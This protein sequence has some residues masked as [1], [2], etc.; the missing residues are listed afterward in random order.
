MILMMISMQ[1]VTSFVHPSTSTYRNLLPHSTTP[2]FI[3]YEASKS[4]FTPS[5]CSSS[6][7]TLF[8]KLWDG[9]ETVESDQVEW[10]LL[11][12]VA[13]LEKD[14]LAQCR[15]MCKDYPKTDIVRFAVPTIREAR[16]H[17]KR[18]VVEDI[19][20][21]PGYVFAQLR[22]CEEVYEEISSLITCRSWMGT[23]R[24]QGHRRL[25]SVPLPLSPEEI[26]SFKGLEDDM[27]KDV[28]KTA[29]ELLK[30]YEGFEVEG[31]VKI[32]EGKHAGEDGIVKRLKGG[33]ISVRLFTYGSQF[34]EW[35]R[36]DQ[37]RPLTELE[38]MRGLT[39]RESPIRQDDFDQS[40]GKPA[41]PKTRGGMEQY[42][43]ENSP[44]FSK[45]NMR[46]ELMGNVKGMRQP[47]NRQQDRV[48]RGDVGGRE[49]R[50]RWGNS[51]DQLQEEKEAWQKYQKGETDQ[52]MKRNANA[53]DV[54]SQWG[55][56]G[57]T[58]KQRKKDRNDVNL[59]DWSQ[60]T[61]TTSSD[62][63]SNDKK[64]DNGED[65]FFNDLM[66]ELS[67]TLED[68]PRPSQSNT[69]PS[70]NSEDD[71]FSSLMS[72]LSEND[73]DGSSAS[74]PPKKDPVDTSSSDPEED[75]FA[76]L[77]KEISMLSDQDP[78][79]STASTDMESILTSDTDGGGM[80]S[81]DDFFAQL[82]SSLSSDLDMEVLAEEAPPK[83]IESKSESKSESESKS[84][85]GEVSATS[86]GT[87]L[88]KLT[89]PVLKSML[90]E[91]GLKVSGKKAELIDRLMN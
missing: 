66:S 1:T 25:P 78:S 52:E 21:Y 36:P 28:E 40:M 87:D 76:S 9:I 43:D 80:D 14:L 53:Y 6:S 19:V 44:R 68:S 83:A 35:L 5:S 27:E 32:L 37:I 65:D 54:D 8:G 12:C 77:E 51:R 75:F 15:E 56:S 26:T 89:V 41:R 7:T 79:P 70:S 22:L 45:R 90:K 74:T 42:S 20:L 18:N 91:K 38:L 82:E 31:M 39:G 2:S 60:F 61:S 59:D 64:S 58:P 48:G 34:D 49:G 67:T 4:K 72:E 33:K 55:R 69:E 3:Q 73:D 24:R 46:N 10:Y 29:E 23:Q 88:S 11:N 86:S 30:A 50:D 57:S 81:E 17:G 63:S 47:R 71:F 84:K 85:S 62:D 16:S 13:G